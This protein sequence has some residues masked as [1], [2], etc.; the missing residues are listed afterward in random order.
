MKFSTIT[1]N[2]FI[3]A[4]LFFLSCAASLVFFFMTSFLLAAALITFG[5]MGGGALEPKQKT[6]RSSFFLFYLRYYFQQMFLFCLLSPL[7][8]PSK[9]K[10]FVSFYSSM[11]AISIKLWQITDKLIIETYPYNLYL[12]KSI[13]KGKYYK[14]N[15][16]HIHITCI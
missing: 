4:L 10:N 16:W 9:S 5:F 1:E 13:N 14:K 2:I 7:W 15:T 11:S 6:T 8:S 12:N 3:A